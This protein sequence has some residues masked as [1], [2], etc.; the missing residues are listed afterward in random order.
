MRFTTER[1]ELDADAFGLTEAGEKMFVVLPNGV[2]E[3]WSRQSRSKTRRQDP[4]A[5]FTNACTLHL[6]QKWNLDVS[7][8]AAMLGRQLLTDEQI[9][10]HKI[11]LE[12]GADLPL[13]KDIWDMWR[14]PD[15]PDVVPVRDWLVGAVPVALFVFIANSVIEKASLSERQRDF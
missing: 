7:E 5:K 8:E 11:S 13:M 12:V 14:D 6:V 10:L 15:N 4:D 2:T 1:K 9:E 3:A